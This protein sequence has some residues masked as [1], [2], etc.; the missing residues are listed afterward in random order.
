MGDVG[1]GVVRAVLELDLEAHPEL[2]DVERHGLPVDPD[3][4]GDALRLGCVELSWRRSSRHLLLPSIVP[5]G[6]GALAT[7]CP[8]IAGP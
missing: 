3:L 1:L 5:S 2:L 4:R 6:D 8:R 7:W